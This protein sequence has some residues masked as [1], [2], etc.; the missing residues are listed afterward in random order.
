MHLSPAVLIG[1]VI[2][3]AMVVVLMLCYVK[4]TGI[5]DNVSTIKRSISAL[6]DEHIALLTE[7]EKTFDLATV[8]AAAEAAAAPPAAPEAG[9]AGAASPR[10]PADVPA[11]GR[12][13]RMQG[14]RKRQN[15]CYN[16]P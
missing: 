9:D 1:T 2:V 12:P 13:G 15:A 10:H 16:Q 5:S 8:K 7:Y 4:L 6:E 14:C 11:P 3:T